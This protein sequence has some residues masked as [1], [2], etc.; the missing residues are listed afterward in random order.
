MKSKRARRQVSPRKVLEEIAADPTASQELR[1]R[2]ASRLLTEQRRDSPK[3]STPDVPGM[4]PVNRRA[5]E[6]AAERHRRLN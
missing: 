5:L 3:P 4:D 1:Y 2:A 6:L